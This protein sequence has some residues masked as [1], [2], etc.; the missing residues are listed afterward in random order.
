MTTSPPVIA[1]FTRTT[2]YRHDSIPAAVAAFEELGAANGLTVL[3]TEDPVV[4]TRAL[5][6]GGCAVAVFASTS[7]DVLDDDAR[8]ALERQ[9]RGG[10]GFL[11]L[12]SAAGTEPGWPFY[13]ELLG[14]VRFDGHPELQPAT[15][16]VEDHAHPAT[17][18]LP[19]RWTWTDEWYDFTANPRPGVRV[20]ASV[21]ELG[22]HGGRMGADHPLVWCHT[23]DA[24]RCL[25]TAL[26]HTGDAYQDPAFRAHL[27]GA[28]SWAGRLR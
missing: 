17:A 15:V 2:G 10:G 24:G 25:V 5:E 19:A 7:G 6:N 16:T 13:A 21:D 12:H 22:Y 3:H 9:V 28:L 23:L 20:L 27:L 18:H 8:R 14:G 11:A 1:V 4:L 26:G